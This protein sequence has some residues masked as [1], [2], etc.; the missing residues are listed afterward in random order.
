VRKDEF[1]YYGSPDPLADTPATQSQARQ[2][3]NW[4]VKS[5][6][7]VNSGRHNVKAGIDLKQT[8]LLEN[9]NF[10]ITDPAFNSPC[11]DARGN[12]SDNTRLTDPAQCGGAG[13]Q[14]NTED[15][16][17]A[18]TT[19]SPGLLPFDLTRRGSLFNFHDTG[20]INQ[21]AVYMQDSITAGQFNFNVGL[22]LD[23]YDGLV[24]KTEPQP[25]LGIAYNIKQTG[26]VLRVAY[27]R[28]METPFNENLLL[29]SAAGAGGLA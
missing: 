18:A 28:T 11:I 8:R 27:A 25:R 17:N 12:P 20:N 9:F 23:R 4:G 29:S 2:L 1:F 7:A 22:R 19:F 13:L 24:S 3:L 14:P 6:V 21:Y 26:T 5:D 10:G 16:P 15:N